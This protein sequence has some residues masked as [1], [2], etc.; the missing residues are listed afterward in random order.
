MENLV[1]LEVFV[2]QKTSELAGEPVHHRKIKGTKIFIEGEVRQIVVNV[3]EEGVLVVL[4]R[5]QVGHP[6]QLI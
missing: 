3:E 5:L 2:S 1:C 4:G 6:I